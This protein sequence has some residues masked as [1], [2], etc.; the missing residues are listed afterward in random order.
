MHNESANNSKPDDPDP[1][2]VSIH[3]AGHLIA[4]VACGRIVEFVSIELVEGKRGCRWDPA[5]KHEWNDYS[6]FLCLLAGPRAQVACATD[7][8]PT[9]KIFLFR[10]RIIQPT[11]D[12]RYLPE[13]IYDYTGWEFDVKPIYSRLRMPEAPSDM[14]FLSSV[15]KVVDV[16]E[17]KLKCF[18]EKETNRLGTLEIAQMLH[19]HK[20]VRGATSAEWVKTNSNLCLVDLDWD[21]SPGIQ[22]ERD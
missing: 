22:S 19:E 10:E 20:I 1:W 11:K 9:E 15:A 8:L 16:A 7:S 6:E 14:G 2:V 5:N 18:F 21:L 12:P 17:E 13:G 3:E 4:G